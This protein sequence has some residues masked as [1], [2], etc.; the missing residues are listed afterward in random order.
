M[1][2]L[3][4]SGKTLAYLVP[5][6]QLLAHRPPQRRPPRPGAVVL[7]PT[8]EL[9]SQ[10]ATEAMALCREGEMKVACIFGGVP[11]RS[12]LE[13]EL[14]LRQAGQWKMSKKSVCEKEHQYFQE[15]SH[16]QMCA[17]SIAMV[18][19]WRV[20]D[21][22]SLCFDVWVRSLCQVYS[23]MRI[24]IPCSFRNFIDWTRGQG[25]QEY[26]GLFVAESYLSHPHI[27]TSTCDL[28]T[29][30]PNFQYHQNKGREHESINTKPCFFGDCKILIL[31]GWDDLR[32][33]R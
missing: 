26:C 32:K 18:D 28:K 29:P 3:P 24:L 1:F 31:R 6:L 33:K 19:Y 15:E 10:I 27:P 7:A 11:Y 5:L 17:F 8:R 12:S 9:A 2:P 20:A 13:D 21:L 4:G 25:G 16:L 14:N 23:F 22:F 30:S